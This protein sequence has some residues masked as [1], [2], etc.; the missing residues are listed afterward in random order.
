MTNEVARLLVINGIDFTNQITVPS[1]QINR[2]DVG[3]TWTDGNKQEHF[4][5][6]R[7]QI[8]GT[9]TYR[10]ESVEMYHLF[11]STIRENKIKTGKN[12]GAVLASLYINNENTVAN[13]YVRFTFEPANNLPFIDGGM[14]YEGFE[15]TVKEV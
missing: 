5:V 4:Y 15:V 6:I 8:E 9:F 2:K 13:T 12:A 7:E 11:C 14:D 3:D 10:P 1:Y